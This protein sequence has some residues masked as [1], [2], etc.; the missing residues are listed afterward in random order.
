MIRCFLYPELSWIYINLCIICSFF[1]IRSF[2]RCCIHTLMSVS[3][4]LCNTMKNN[5]HRCTVWQ[6]RTIESKT[7][8][9]CIHSGL[10][11]S[12]FICLS[13]FLIWYR[14]IDLFLY[15]QNLHTVSTACKHQS[16]RQ[17][18]ISYIH[19]FRN[20]S[21][22]HIVYHNPVG[23][24]LSCLPFIFIGCFTDFKFRTVG[25]YFC[26]IFTRF[27]L[28]C[29]W[30][31]QI[32][33]CSR[34][35]IFPLHSI[36]SVQC[37]AF[38]SDCNLFPIFQ[39]R[40]FCLPAIVSD[41]G[42]YTVL[43]ICLC[44]ILSFQKLQTCRYFI[45]DHNIQCPY[46]RFCLRNRNFIIYS[47]SY[48]PF[49]CRHIFCHFKF[50]RNYTFYPYNICIHGIPCA[51]HTFIAHRR[52][53][54]YQERISVLCNVFWNINFGFRSHLY[55]QNKCISLIICKSFLL[56]AFCFC[57]ADYLLSFNSC[58]KLICHILTCIIYD[59]YLWSILYFQAFLQCI[60]NH[61]W[62]K[63]IWC[64]F[65]LDHI[66]E[67]FPLY[68][69]K[70][71]IFRC[72][73]CL[74]PGTV[75]LS[76]SFLWSL[77][78]L[79]VSK[80]VWGKIKISKSLT[81][82]LSLKVR[83]IGVSWAIHIF[84]DYSLCPFLFRTCF[85]NA[86]FSAGIPHIELF[87][88]RE[89]KIKIICLI[90]HIHPAFLIIRLYGNIL[91][92]HI[93][94][95][96]FKEIIIWQNIDLIQIA[97]RRDF[98][99]LCSIYIPDC[100]MTTN[101]Q[102]LFCPMFQKLEINLCRSYRVNKN[103]N[104]VSGKA[105][106]RIGLIILPAKAYPSVILCFCYGCTDVITSLRILNSHKTKTY[107][108]NIPGS[109][110]SNIIITDSG[111]S[112]LIVLWYSHS[113]CISVA[114]SMIRKSIPVLVIAPKDFICGNSWLVLH[115]KTVSIIHCLIRLPYFYPFCSSLH[116]IHRQKTQYCLHDKQHCEQ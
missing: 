79:N 51:T 92:T 35:N 100:S 16:L 82:L 97:V 59:M 106:N 73:R 2:Y 68:C 44:C 46:I 89:H 66:L 57:T 42:Q 87:L 53:V 104:T 23:N 3:F 8:S 77:L 47:V 50:R 72:D 108:H 33:G 93:I 101:R 52:M 27:L 112:R 98:Y 21:C 99:C 65:S 95:I 83:T 109:I 107:V 113:F 9:V 34:N 32:I 7:I 116:H 85:F 24:L 25:P 20:C 61:Q 60:L 18:N 26:Q 40:A 96:Y 75:N 10:Y 48:F 74:F 6:I 67:L 111:T 88:M 1:C 84:S 69:C 19:I 54:R 102:Y 43:R 22:R 81:K 31:D 29:V 114:S 63:F 94:S 62:A 14:I 115:I 55:F 45:C 30:I 80:T 37:L 39:R 13:C 41:S 103:S 58:I 5:C 64:Y 11:L 49:I 86:G 36:W 110:S 91:G 17:T 71:L 76:Y 78:H 56:K 28:S 90:Q 4:L 15:S 105:N 70:R 12:C 38:K